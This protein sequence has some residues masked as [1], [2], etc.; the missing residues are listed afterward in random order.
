ML[1]VCWPVKGR[2]KPH[3]LLRQV[4]KVLT[5]L[6]GLLRLSSAYLQPNSTRR[7]RTSSDHADIIFVDKQLPVRGLRPPATLVNKGSELQWKVSLT[8][9]R[10]FRGIVGRVKEE[11]D[12]SY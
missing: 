6:R 7:Q 3:L 9:P 1:A 4:V 5:M 11:E 2:L 8:V 10:L 12:A